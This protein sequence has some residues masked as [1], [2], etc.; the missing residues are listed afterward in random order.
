MG[1][2]DLNNWSR[3]EIFDFFSFVS[4]PFY[5]VSFKVDVTNLYKY[6]K[7]NKQSFYL[8]MIHC[9]NKAMNTVKA[10]NYTIRDNEIYLLDKRN[11]SFTDKSKDDEFFKIVSVDYLEKLDEFVS[12][13]KEVSANQKEFIDLTME[14]DDLIYFTCL[15]EIRLTALTNERELINP[16]SKDNNIPQLA[17]GKYEM[18]NDKVELTLSL[19]V[20][21]RFVD[22]SDISLFVKELEKIISEL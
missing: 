11:P 13:A 1:K 7:E 18:N 6:C 17:W 10:F 16:S 20:N 15:P 19:E 21:H 14:K 22:G 8:S 4:N 12:N 2:V 3:K 9:C 5:M